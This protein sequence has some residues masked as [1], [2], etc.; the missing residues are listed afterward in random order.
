[1]LRH[2]PFI[3]FILGLTSATTLFTGTL[4][5]ADAIGFQ[6][7]RDAQANVP[8]DVTAIKYAQN[9]SFAS[10]DD[11]LDQL[12]NVAH[13]AGIEILYQ[14]YG[15]VSTLKHNFT[16]AFTVSAIENGARFL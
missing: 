12:Q 2:A 8:V 16:S 7:L 9:A 11:A 10:V 14:L 1:M 6:T 13:V 4:L 15:S 3:A 5:G